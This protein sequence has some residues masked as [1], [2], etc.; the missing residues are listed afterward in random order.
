[1]NRFKDLHIPITFR[2]ETL[3]LNNN[4]M[5]IVLYL[6]FFIAATKKAFHDFSTFLSHTNVYS[7]V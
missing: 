4:V 1:M 3:S 5:G 2:V 7:S 6:L